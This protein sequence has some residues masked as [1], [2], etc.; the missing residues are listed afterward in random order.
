MIK[1]LAHLCFFTDNYQQMVNFYQ[2]KLGLKLKFTFKGADE[3]EFGCYFEA[4]DLSF[5]EIFDQAGAIKQWGGQLKELDQ[6]GRYQHFC[7]QVD[8]LEAECAA[9]K[10]KGVEITPIKVG[11]DESKQAWIADPDG[12][13]IELMA[14][15]D[16]SWQL[17]P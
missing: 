14:Y 4:G 10:Q 6:E 2:Q 9:L 13:R 16:K 15:T 8:G 12:N 1:R 11:M 17:R 3:Q 7:L 5:I